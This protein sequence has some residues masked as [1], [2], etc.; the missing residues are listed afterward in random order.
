MLLFYAHSYISFAE[1]PLYPSL[2]TFTFKFL[3]SFNALVG[4][5]T[6]FEAKKEFSNHFLIS[7]LWCDLHGVCRS[8]AICSILCSQGHIRTRTLQL[9]N[10]AWS[11]HFS[12]STIVYIAMQ[13][14]RGTAWLRVGQYLTS[15]HSITQ[16]QGAKHVI[17]VCVCKQRHGVSPLF[18]H[19]FDR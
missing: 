5:N 18:P 3:F 11:G 15:T 4:C 14:R 2:T 17:K 6:S 1:L 19:N 8:F 9:V 7:L 12:D 13:L 16:A 10:N